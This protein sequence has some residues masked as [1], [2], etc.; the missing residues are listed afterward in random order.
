MPDKTVTLYNKSGQPMEFANSKQILDAAKGKGWT[1]QPPAQPQSQTQPTPQSQTGT[2]Q[3]TPGAQKQG[4]IRSFGQ[5]LN[6]FHA[7]PQ[8]TP[9]LYPNDG[10]GTQA[11]DDMVNARELKDKVKHGNYGDAAGM[12]LGTVGSFA[13]PELI[14]GVGKGV[15]GASALIRGEKEVPMLAK[16]AKRA[17]GTAREL[18]A[19]AD[20]SRYVE[21]TVQPLHDALDKK[22]EPIH[23]AMDKTIITANRA[24]RQ[25]IKRLAGSENP[26]IG[27]LAEELQ[28]RTAFNYREIEGLRRKALDLAR[29]GEEQW[30]PIL[31]DFAKELDASIQAEANKIG[32]GK[33]RSELQAT[34]KEIR[35]AARAGVATAKGKQGILRGTLNAGA[36]ML[37]HIGA[38]GVGAG[39]RNATESVTRI[40][41]AVKARMAKI[42]EKLGVDVKTL[43]FGLSKSEK[44]GTGIERTGQAMQGGNITGRALPDMIKRMLGGQ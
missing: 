6:P 7:T 16:A 42:A 23:Q 25:F 43:D 32:V 27:K 15:K 36:G 5:G 4:F 8:G 22:W 19:N 41:P 37:D 38:T 17:P 9:S 26:A 12:A 44:I 31:N 30:A 10:K 13:G 28:G 40:E 11:I 20:V 39:V 34:Y 14:K 2:D 33:L 24:T 18:R 29:S 1:D 35:D 3:Q 21:R